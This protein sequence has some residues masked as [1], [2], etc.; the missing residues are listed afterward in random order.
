MKGTGEEPVKSQIT[1]F[2]IRAFQTLHLLYH[3]RQPVFG[4][5]KFEIQN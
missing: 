5:D 4:T 3:F 1:D 2:E